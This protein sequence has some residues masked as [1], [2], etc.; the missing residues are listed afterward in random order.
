MN[1]KLE[2]TLRIT[3]DRTGLRRRLG[4]PMESDTAFFVLGRVYAELTGLFGDEHCRVEL[5]SATGVSPE[6]IAAMRTF[7]RRH[8]QV[9]DALQARGEA[10]VEDPDILEVL[11][12]LH[13]VVIT[14][15]GSGWCVSLLS[16]PRC[17][18]RHIRKRA[19]QN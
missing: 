18:S 19:Q 7:P 15:T 5:D 2:I 12:L 17:G 4:W 8:K 6:L 1:E 14:P 9:L 3:L 11:A 13:D 16:A 10:M